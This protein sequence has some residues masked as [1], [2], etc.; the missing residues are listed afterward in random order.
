MRHLLIKTQRRKSE[1]AEEKEVSLSTM[2]VAKARA[3]LM[4]LQTQ[5]E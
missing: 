5:K 3:R 4:A 1:P 2:D